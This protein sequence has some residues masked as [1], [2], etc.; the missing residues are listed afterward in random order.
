MATTLWPNHI[1]AHIYRDLL[2][3]VRSNV[4]PVV[5]VTARTLCLVYKFRDVINKPVN[6]TGLFNIDS[7]FISLFRD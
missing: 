4:S 3:L 2:F 6:S 5:S 7:L 1:A